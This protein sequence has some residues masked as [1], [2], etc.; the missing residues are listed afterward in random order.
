MFSPLVLLPKLLLPYQYHSL[1]I[2]VHVCA[3]LYEEFDN[4]MVLGSALCGVPLETDSSDHHNHKCTAL[5]FLAEMLT[6]IFTGMPELCL[7]VEEQQ[8]RGIFE[9]IIRSKED[10]VGQVALL[11][12]LSTIAKVCL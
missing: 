4:F 2:F 9:L 8:I 12:T 5:P 6:A 3:R 1:S 11:S 7:R 10:P